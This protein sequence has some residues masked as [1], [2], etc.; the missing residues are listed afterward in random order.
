MPP[1][2]ALAY[3]S[4]FEL[5]DLVRDPWSRTRRP[6]DPAY[7]AVLEEL[8]GQLVAHLQ[9][10]RDPILNGAVTSPA[11]PACAGLASNESVAGAAVQRVTM[12]VPASSSRRNG[13]CVQPYRADGLGR[14]RRPQLRP[15]A[16]AAP[17]CC[18]IAGARAAY[19]R[20]R[21]VALGAA[22]TGRRSAAT[23]CGAIQGIALEQL[24]DAGLYLCAGLA[25]CPPGQARALPAADLV[26]VAT[27]CGG[28]DHY[29]TMPLIRILYLSPS[30]VAT[31]SEK[32]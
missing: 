23:A 3:H 11:A 7:S 32:I 28:I 5:Y 14:V 25:Q 9:A 16:P 29:A 12:I 20:A 15:S 31:A 27:E 10:T 2:H 19:Q 18:E 8:R 6:R 26:D 22:G 21:P 17:R 30:R 4:P 1:N 13:M 24:H